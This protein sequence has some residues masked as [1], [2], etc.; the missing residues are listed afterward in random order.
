MEQRQNY[1]KKR[2]AILKA[3]RSTTTHPTAEWVYQT[4]KPQHPDLSLGTVYRNI[5]R[6]KENGQII[7]VGVVNGQERFDGN[8]KPHSHFICSVCGRVFDVGGD[9]LG[10]EAAERI[11]D[12]YRFQVNS[13]EVVFRGICAECLNRQSETPVG[14]NHGRNF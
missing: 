3:I 4:L 9:Y 11:A 14:E 6:F 10:R 12:R 8:V 5:A 7:S 2:E 1:S 13:S